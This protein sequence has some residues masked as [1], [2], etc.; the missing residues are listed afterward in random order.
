MYDLTEGGLTANGSS[1]ARQIKSIVRDLEG[2]SE[3]QTWTIIADGTWDSASLQ[4][5]FGPTADGPWQT[6]SDVTFDADGAQITE[7]S[8]E[9]WVRATLSSAGGST[10]VNLWVG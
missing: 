1:T 7:L 10:D 5:D 3:R 2:S 9:L 4:L 6:S 8:R